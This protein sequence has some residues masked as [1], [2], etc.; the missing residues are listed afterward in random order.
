M[1]GS[2]LWKNTGQKFGRNTWKKVMNKENEWDQMMETEELEGPVKKI[3]CKE[4]V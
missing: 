1:D 3:T 4:I 2:A